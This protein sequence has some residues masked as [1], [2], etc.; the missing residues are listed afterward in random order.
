MFS[1]T[2]EDW[3]VRPPLMDIQDQN[4]IG[5]L[6]VKPCTQARVPKPKPKGLGI[7]LTTQHNID[8]SYPLPKDGRGG[9]Q[10]D[11]ER[12]CSRTSFIDKF[13]AGHEQTKCR[14]PMYSKVWINLSGELKPYVGLVLIDPRSG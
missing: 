7:T 10:V 13:S 3:I 9:P 6:I 4:W 8:T 5:E 1:S 2:E 12:T 14:S 11:S